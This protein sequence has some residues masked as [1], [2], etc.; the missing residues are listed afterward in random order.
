MNEIISGLDITVKEQHQVFELILFELKNSK[1]WYWD[2]SDF[3]NLT[4]NFEISRSNSM[5]IVNANH[6]M[7]RP[8]WGS[9]ICI[10]NEGSYICIVNEESTVAKNNKQIFEE[11]KAIMIDKSEK[12]KNR[13]NKK[14]RL[15]TSNQIDKALK[16]PRRIKRFFKWLNWL[17]WHINV[18]YK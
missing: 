16:K 11:I 15:E 8:S 6:I 7:I 14:N 13:I 2:C 5:G 9:Y 17:N 12:E 1:Y 3:I 18:K 4:Y 10:V